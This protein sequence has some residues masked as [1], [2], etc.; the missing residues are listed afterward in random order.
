[1]KSFLIS[2]NRDSL[3][4]IRIAGIE[5]VV[6]QNKE[7]AV[8]ILNEKLK[9]YKLNLNLYDLKILKYIIK[10][11]E[12]T[13]IIPKEV[14]RKEDIQ[15][16]IGNQGD[17]YVSITEPLEEEPKKYVAITFDDGPSNSTIDL[18]NL[19]NKYNVKA[20]FFLLGNNVKRYPQAVKYIYENNYEIGNHSYSHSDFTKISIDEVEYEIDKTQE[21]IYDL[22]QSYPKVFRF[23]YGKYNDYILNFINYPIILWNCDS[24]DW[25]SL[26]KNIIFRNVLKDLSDNS[27]IIFH[28]FTN[29]RKES[30]ENIIKY[31]KEENYEFVTISE[32]FNFHK[33]ENIIYGKIYR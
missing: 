9:S 16:I 15:I 30:I 31:L 20:T 26:D 23:P 17:D 7:E 18:V 32:L 12:I 14:T 5:G 4:G 1:M 3:I 19:I 6:P 28:D 24:E 29:Y 22:I 8:K 27:I 11:N 33:E 10:K 13:F 2:D 25:R 21:V